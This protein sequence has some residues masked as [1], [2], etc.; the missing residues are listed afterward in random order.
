MPCLQSSASVGLFTQTKVNVYTHKV[1]IRIR[2][3]L[4]LCLLHKTRLVS[5]DW[6]WSMIF[7]GKKVQNDP[8]YCWFTKNHNLIKKFQCRLI[9]I[10][11]NKALWLD[12]TRHVMNFNQS[13]SI[14]SE[15]YYSEFS[16]YV[17][18]VLDWRMEHFLEPLTPDLQSSMSKSFWQ[19]VEPFWNIAHTKRNWPKCQS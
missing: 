10:H 9:Y 4:N 1:K 8:A 3:D 6:R 7:K 19:L 12:V 14:I 11:W 2:F 5:F 13:E 16:Y 18:A 17:I 15:L